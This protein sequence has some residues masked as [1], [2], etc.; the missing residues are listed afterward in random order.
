MK[1]TYQ[2]ISRKQGADSKPSNELRKSRE[3]KMKKIITGFI[4]AAAVTVPRW[5]QAAAPVVD[6]NG[7]ASNVLSISA[8]L[9]GTLTSTGGGVGVLGIR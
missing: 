1:T 8:T 2:D 6:N 9:N 4:L 7:G 5:A 3:N